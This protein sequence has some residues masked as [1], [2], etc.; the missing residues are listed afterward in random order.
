MSVN[1]NLCKLENIILPSNLNGILGVEIQLY[2]PFSH[3]IVKVSGVAAGLAP[4]CLLLVPTGVAQPCCS[5]P[6]CPTAP[7]SVKT[8]LYKSY[9]IKTLRKPSL[10]QGKIYLHFLLIYF[11]LTIY[12][13]W[14]LFL[15]V[16][17]MEICS[18]NGWLTH[19]DPLLFRNV[20]FIIY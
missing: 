2:N 13:T 1:L 20:K 3:R 11:S 9:L 17:Q 16:V 18:P 6:E 14:N 8:F 15:Q 5:V 10:S 4:G 12:S 7:C 19:R